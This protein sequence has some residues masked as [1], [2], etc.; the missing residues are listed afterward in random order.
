MEGETGLA[1]LG[2]IGE[3]LVELVIGRTS[4]NLAEVLHI[5]IFV[6]VVMAR[7]F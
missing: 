7:H 3:F 4:R 6:I 5:D 1:V 2:S